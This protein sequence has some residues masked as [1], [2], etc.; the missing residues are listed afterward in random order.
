MIS[1][2][3]QTQKIQIKISLFGFQQ[4]GKTTLFNSWT[5]KQQS[6]EYLPTDEMIFEP[7]IYNYP[8]S[9]SNE[10]NSNNSNGNENET[11]Q[12]P[13]LL[14]D[15]GYQALM[16]NSASQQS[17]IHL[18]SEGVNLQIFV[19]SLNSMDSYEF[20]EGAFEKGI[21]FH[22]GNPAYFIFKDLFLRIIN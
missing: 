2:D 5:N 12:I 13:I 1:I 17:T 16:T 20:V 22:C 3:E 6:V 4:C 9:I 7:F 8:I 14:C 19:L 21:Y 11:M 15:W 18:Y 10:N